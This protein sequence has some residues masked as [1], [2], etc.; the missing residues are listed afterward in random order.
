MKAGKTEIVCIMDK[1]GSMNSIADDARGGFNALM[2]EQ[3]ADLKDGEECL[4]SLYLFSDKY[5]TVFEG[6]PLDEV[7]ELDSTNYVPGGMTALYDAVG[8]TVDAVGQRLAETPEDERPSQVL[9]V[10]VT[11]GAEN[12]SN[13]YTGT[14]IAEMIEHQQDTYNWEFIFLAANIDTDMFAASLNISK[15]NSYSFQADAAGLANTYGTI[16]TRMSKS[17]SIS[18]GD[19]YVDADSAVDSEDDATDTP[20]TEMFDFSPDAADSDTDSGDMDSD[21]ESQV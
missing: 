14:R 17:R 13:E 10:I 7:P 11:D 18:R 1:S 5:Q 16:S 12:S 20:L 19:S 9:V 6:K 8:R 3:L 15:G 2:K 4:V 21:S